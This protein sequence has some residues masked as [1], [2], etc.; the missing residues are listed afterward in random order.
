MGAICPGDLLNQTQLEEV[1]VYMNKV[2]SHMGYKGVLYA[3]LMINYN[4]LHNG[5][6]EKDYSINFLEFNCRFVPET[7]WA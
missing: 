3:G 4:R 2:V 5:L 1:Q 7:Q 6:N